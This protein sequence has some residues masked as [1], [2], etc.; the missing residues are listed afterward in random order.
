MEGKKSSFRDHA[1]RE[2]TQVNVVEHFIAK[3]HQR[4][5]ELILCAGWR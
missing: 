1:T 3:G 2:S 4:F 5:A